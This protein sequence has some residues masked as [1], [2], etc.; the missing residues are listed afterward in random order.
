MLLL[1]HLLACEAFALCEQVSL[2]TVIIVL[3]SVLVARMNI[4]ESG[5]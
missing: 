5:R 2:D 1:N 3:M 4:A